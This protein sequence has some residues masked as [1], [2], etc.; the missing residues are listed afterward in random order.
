MIR[1]SIDEWV[2]SLL[3]AKSKAAA[4]T[5][6]DIKKEVFQNNMS[7]LY[8]SIIKNILNSNKEIPHG[9]E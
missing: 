7:Y 2:N 5:Q 6:S 1:G 8:N 4:L 3:N 9:K